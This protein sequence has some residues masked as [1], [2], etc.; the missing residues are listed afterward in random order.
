MNYSFRFNE[1]FLL[2]E[3]LFILAIKNGYLLSS[4]L[5]G[6]LPDQHEVDAAAGRPEID[7]LAVH[8]AACEDLRRPINR[9]TY[10]R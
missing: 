5:E 8:L 4:F 9:R 2:T 6:S 10:P 7:A 1:D 3:N